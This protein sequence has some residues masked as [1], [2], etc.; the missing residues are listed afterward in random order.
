[1]KRV[2]LDAMFAGPISGASMNPVRSLAPALVF[3]TTGLPLDLSDTPVVGVLLAV[4]LSKV[5]F[6]PISERE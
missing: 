4:C 2:G 3:R 1:M 6:L 5:I